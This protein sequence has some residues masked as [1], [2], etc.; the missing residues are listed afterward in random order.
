MFPPV[1]VV[2][3]HFLVTNDGHSVYYEV[4]GNPDG[5]PLVYLHGGPG[6][7]TSVNARMMFDPDVFR[8]V[9][10]DQRG[11]GRSRPLASD[12]AA[13]C[14]TNTTHHLL[15]D[16]EEIREVLHIEQW[17]V[18]GFSWGTTLALAYGEQFPSRCRGILAG[19]VTTTSATEVHWITEDVGAIF[20]REHAQL[21]DFI[22]PELRSF[23]VVD[24]Y[25]EML[26]GPDLVQAAR[27]ADEWCRWEDAH[28]S[29]APGHRHFD[30]FD[31]PEFR[32]LFARLV[33][34][35]WRHAAFLDEDQLFRDAYKLAHVPLVLIHGR[36]DVSSPLL[37]PWRL[38]QLLPHS[39][40]LVLEESGHGDGDD[41]MPTVQAALGRLSVTP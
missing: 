13:D 10:L 28:V 21:T 16:L 36:F 38:H 24:A 37:T 14:A 41:F 19:L 31:D 34:H 35:Y 2:E 27:A 25:A 11:C 4:F 39:E 9:L 18:V 33:T 3:D 12:P 17:L 7:G 40:F 6:V 15:A 1:D 26:W 32:L 5:I 8:I 22:P 20:P 30:K 29:L 23:P